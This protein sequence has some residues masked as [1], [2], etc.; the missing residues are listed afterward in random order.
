MYVSCPCELLCLLL[1]QDKYLKLQLDVVEPMR[2]Q[3]ILSCRMHGSWTSFS[4]CL[5]L[6]NFYS[7]R[8]HTG[9]IDCMITAFLAMK[10]DF[11][12]NE[13]MS[14]IVLYC[15]VQLLPRDVLEN[16]GPQPDSRLMPITLA[17]QH[18]GSRYRQISE[19]K[20]AWSAKQV[21]GYPG[22]SREILSQ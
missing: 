20:A 13:K 4:F 7:L 17:R 11:T 21:P 14:F 6:A 15:Q 2:S 9:L 22:L 10:I 5:Y 8:K 3:F 16:S 1:S 18:S 19:F 12:V